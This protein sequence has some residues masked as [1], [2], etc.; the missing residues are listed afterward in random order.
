MKLLVA[1]IGAAL[2][3]LALL[4]AGVKYGKDQ[5]A[6]A[7][8]LRRQR[9]HIRVLEKIMTSEHPEYTLSVD[10]SD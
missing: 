4:G 10:W 6:Q 1:Q 5:E 7:A 8:V 3:V 9:E 2:A